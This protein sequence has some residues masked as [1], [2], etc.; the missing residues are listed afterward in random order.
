MRRNELAGHCRLL[1][2]NREEASKARQL[3]SWWFG[4]LV[5]NQNHHR[6][7]L[8]RYGG[9]NMTNMYENNAEAFDHDDRCFKPITLKSVLNGLKTLFH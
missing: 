2:R 3:K 8:K 6:Y 7:R 4:I 1:R 9:G 5:A